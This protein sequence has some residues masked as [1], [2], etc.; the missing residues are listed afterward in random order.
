MR[1]KVRPRRPIGGP[2]RCSFCGKDR[3]QVEKLIA[4]PGVY[5]CCACVVSAVGELAKPRCQDVCVLAGSA[6]PLRPGGQ[7]TTPDEGL[8]LVRRK[9]CRLR[10]SAGG[11]PIPPARSSRLNTRPPGP[12]RAPQ[13]AILRGPP[14]LRSGCRILSSRQGLR[15]VLDMEEDGELR[16]KMRALVGLLRDIRSD[17]AA[18][19]MSPE[20][21]DQL[22]GAIRDLEEELGG[23]A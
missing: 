12:D 3:D 19:Q 1:L 2:L 20:I 10:K 14:L 9:A 21:L 8:R 4:G 15:L 6:C 7:G 11:P 5:I 23:S 18:D 17:P 16:I 22:E 13:P